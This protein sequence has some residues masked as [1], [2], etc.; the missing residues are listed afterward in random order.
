MSGIFIPT[1]T[2]EQAEEMLKA[3]QEQGLV[4]ASAVGIERPGYKK[5]PRTPSGNYARTFM[6]ATRTYFVIPPEDGIGFERWSKLSEMLIPMQFGQQSYENIKRYMQGFANDIVGFTEIGPM[7]VETMRRIQSFLDGIAEMG[8]KR[9]TE[10]AYLC[11]LF[12]VEENED[13]K[14]WSVAKAEQKIEDWGEY[15]FQDFFLLAA[16][17][18]TEFLNDYLKRT[19]ELKTLSGLSTHGNT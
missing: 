16:G 11:T 3:L 2:P 17:L 19:E 10:A 14:T 8:E 5:L 6:T 4:N 12:I 13:L 9:Y 1:D 18:S 15:D 7:K